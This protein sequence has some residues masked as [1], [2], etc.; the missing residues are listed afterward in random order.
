MIAL[1][2][3]TTALAG[4]IDQPE[5]GGLWGTPTAT[6]GTAI[7]WN[8]AGLA[9]GSGTRLMLE[10]APVTAAVAFER[11][12]PFGNGGK[13]VYTTLGMLPFLGLVSDFGVDGLGV[14]AGLA[15]PFAN[16]AGSL[17][18]DPHGSYHLISGENQHLHFMLGAGYEIADRVALGV[19]GALVRGTYTAELDMEALTVLDAEISALGQESGYTD[20]MVEDP[21]YG[22]RLTYDDVNGSTAITFGLGA[23]VKV[24]DNLAVG[25]GYVHGFRAEHTGDFDVALGCPPQHDVLGRFGA[26]AYGVCDATMTGDGFIGYQLPSRLHLG[27]AWE[28]VDLLRLEL[29]GGWV[30]W[31]VFT[32]YEISLTNIAERSDLANPEAA[33]LIEQDRLWARDASDSVW[34]AVDA[35][36]QPI[37]RLTLAGRLGYDKAAIPTYALSPNNWDA[38]TVKLGGMAAFAVVRQ[39]ELGVSVQ[40]WLPQA[41]E[42]TESGFGVT[43]DPAARAEDRWFYPQ[44]NGTYR[45]SITRIGVSLRV[46]LAPPEGA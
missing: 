1:L 13:D 8:P 44:T 27:V 18:P 38:N 17:E 5:V 35:K 4:A 22:A 16:A 26:E 12:D 24:L 3:T 39:L 10:I 21:D 15:V 7:W 33:P 40:Q 36:V 2:L 6:D 41:R 46:H 28:P 31:H 42:N 9:A 45:A 32:D 20:D 37:E 34:F 29:M 43:L 14:G 11:T 25:V 23:R 19:S 30:G